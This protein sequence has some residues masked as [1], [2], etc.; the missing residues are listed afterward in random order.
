MAASLHGLLL[1]FAPVATATVASQ[2]KNQ[3][4]APSVTCHFTY[5][6]EDRVLVTHSTQKPYEVA[7][8]QVGSY[9]LLKVVFQERPRDLASIKIYVYADDDPVFRPIH[10]AT[11]AYPPQARP[12]QRWGFTGFH[13]VYEPHRDGELEYWCE[14]TPRGRR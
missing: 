4:P 13:R 14:M 11:Y 12:G 2:A 3:A 6:G 5:G 9:F 10:H 1:L 8:I 7:P